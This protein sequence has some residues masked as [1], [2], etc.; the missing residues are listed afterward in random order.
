MLSKIMF[1]K[2]KTKIKK[3][4]RKRE[5]K[6]ERRYEIKKEGKKERTKENKRIKERKEKKGS[7]VLR[8]NAPPPFLLT[9]IF[10][11]ANCLQQFPFLG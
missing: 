5:R 8:I 11:R 10:F 9:L 2:N 6:K 1:D 3:Y 4:K 7:N